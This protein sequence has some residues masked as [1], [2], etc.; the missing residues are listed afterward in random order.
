[1]LNQFLIWRLNEEGMNKKQSDFFRRIIMSYNSFHNGKEKENF[2]NEIYL[3]MNP[4]LLKWVSSILAKRGVYLEKSEMLSKS[5]DCFLF[6]LEH[7]KPHKKNISVP[8][9]FYSYTFFY[10]KIQKTEKKNDVL[11]QQQSEKNWIDSNFDI[12]YSVMDE[13]RNFRNN[14][15]DNY[16]SI[17][18]DALMSLIPYK[19]DRQYRIKKSNISLIRYQESK[20]IFKI[21]IDYLLRR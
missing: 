21:V 19:K 12:I 2:R 4:F 3:E 18:D 20:K 1:M 10:L 5:W 14:L 17:F 9:H 11:N 7:F 6:C 15:D 13:L 16:S 8:N